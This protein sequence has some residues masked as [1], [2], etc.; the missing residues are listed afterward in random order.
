MLL[1][2]GVLEKAIQ[3]CV[4]NNISRA[5]LHIYFNRKLVGNAAGVVV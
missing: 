3:P 5:L 2:I 4:P 1:K